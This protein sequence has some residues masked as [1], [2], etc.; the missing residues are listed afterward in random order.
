MDIA[1]AQIC[2]QIPD[3]FIYSC[4]EG[5][6]VSSCGYKKISVERAHRSFFDDF[7]GIKI[8]YTIQFS[9]KRQISLNSVIAEGVDITGSEVEELIGR[10]TQFRKKIIAG[11]TDDEIDKL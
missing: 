2:L 8:T 11:L 7:G 6:Y 3:N 5:R 4:Y 10:M 9:G 1:I